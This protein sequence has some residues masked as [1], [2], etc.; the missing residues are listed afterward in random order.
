ML[1]GQTARIAQAV[2]ALVMSARIFRYIFKMFR[3]G[4]RF[5][6][7]DRDLDMMIDDLTLSGG[8]RAGTY[9]QVLDLVAAQKVFLPACAVAPL[10]GGD[11]QHALTCG[12]RH[13]FDA[14]IAPPQKFAVI[15]DLPDFRLILGTYFGI[16]SIL[17]P[18][19]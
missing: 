10:I 1:A 5:E 2:H 12:F 17:H 9:C 4:Q 11:L 6:H 13:F 16:F 15:L 3:P 19:S 18:A 8:Q 7:L 14:N